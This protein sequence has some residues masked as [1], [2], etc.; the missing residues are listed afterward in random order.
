MKNKK[1]ILYVLFP[2][3]LTISLYVV[4]YSSIE[5]KPQ[6]AGFWFILVMGMSVGVALTRF[7]YWFNIKNKE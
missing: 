4:F 7:L 3:I 1:G 6:N 2:V 5:S